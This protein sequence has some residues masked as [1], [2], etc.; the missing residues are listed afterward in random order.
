MS[1]DDQRSRRPLTQGEQ[2]VLEQIQD[3]YGEQNT[4]QDVFISDNDEAVIL[5]KDRN[6][7]KGLVAVLTNLAAMY[8]DGTIASVE[9]LRNQWLC[10]Q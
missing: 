4:Q 7:T 2:F 6:G 10:P 9:D 5:V 1:H 8:E 3:M